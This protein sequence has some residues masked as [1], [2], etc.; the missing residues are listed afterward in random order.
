MA[1]SRTEPLL[2]A[3]DSDEDFEALQRLMRGL[4][5]PN[6]IYRCADGEEVLDVLRDRAT[7]D[8]RP[9][10]L[11]S[12]I[13]LDLNMPGLDGRDVLVQLKQD[14]RFREIPVVIFTTSSSPSDIEFCYQ[15]GANAYL[16]KPMGTQALQQTV[17]AFI[18]F[19]LNSNT[20]PT[21]TPPALTEG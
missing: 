9:S 20:P 17:Q 15:Q 3:E 2:I 7:S 6:P 13:L 4:A 8:N 11:P 14:Q 21:F 12:V 18:N 5:V 10:F 19:W 16:I 1:V